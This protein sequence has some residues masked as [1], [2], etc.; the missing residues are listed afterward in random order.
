[1]G[2]DP[3]ELVMNISLDRL[4]EHFCPVDTPPWDCSG[5]V[6]LDLV[7]ECFENEVF[8]KHPVGGDEGQE[9]RTHAGRIAWLAKTGWTDTIELDV[10]IPGITPIGTW[11]VLDGNHRLYAAIFREDLSIEASVSG[12]IDFAEELEFNPQETIGKNSL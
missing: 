2:E 8:V 6:T 9:A 11:P 10:G 7:R 4:R 5:E 1:M 3:D 12:S